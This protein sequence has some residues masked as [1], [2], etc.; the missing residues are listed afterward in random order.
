MLRP[1]PSSPGNGTLKPG[2]DRL[3]TSVIRDGDNTLGP[4]L[5]GCREV[6]GNG[7]ARS[8]RELCEKLL[9]NTPLRT[10][11]GSPD[12]PVKMPLVLHPPISALTTR[13]E[14]PPN[15]FPLPAGSS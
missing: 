11:K 1:R 14:L 15:F 12:W 4:A 3:N 9:V 10:L 6:D 7:P 8:A 2:V 13:P 5:P